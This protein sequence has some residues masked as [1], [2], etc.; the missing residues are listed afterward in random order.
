MCTYVGCAGPSARQ[1]SCSAR[2]SHPVLHP[3][4][5]TRRPRIRRPDLRTPREDDLRRHQ[6]A[7]VHVSVTFYSQN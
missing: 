5:G 3:V 4:S 7:G 2:A 6:R 1:A